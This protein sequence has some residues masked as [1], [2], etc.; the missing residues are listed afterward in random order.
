ML[1]LLQLTLEKRHE[2]KLTKGL[3]PARPKPTP[4]AGA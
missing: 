2:I 1:L 3:Y 4:T